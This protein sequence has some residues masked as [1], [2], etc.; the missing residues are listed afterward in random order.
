[1]EKF[2]NKGDFLAKWASG[3]LSDHEKEAFEKIKDYHYY[4]AIL[5]GTDLL[6]TPFYDKEKNYRQVHE[7]ISKRKKVIPLV[8]RWMYFVA[9]ASIV[10][11]VGYYSSFFYQTSHY[12]TE[13]GKQLI[14][15]LPSE[16]EVIL[17]ATSKLHY[18]KGNWKKERTLVLDGQA[19]FKVT[20]GSPFKVKTKNGFIT[21]LGTQF[22]VN[23]HADIF[24]VICFK[25]KVRVERNGLSKVITDGEGIRL[26]NNT[27]FE[28]WSNAINKDAPS[29]IHG[30]SCF[31]NAQLHQVIKAMEN[32]Y[33][34]TFLDDDINLE[35][36]FTGSFTHNNLKKAL[37]TVFEP[38]EIKFT[39]ANE[40]TINLV[41][42]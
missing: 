22:T 8:P 17:N 26:V 42:K 38:L 29:W 31:T 12:H 23:S 28:K 20:K 32:Q 21:V 41:A 5:E 15:K 33:D 10:L 1:M 3:E 36:R 37:R 39:F 13:Y 40:N 11:V 27:S 25:G 4:K 6:K 16:S 35:L 18:K 9:A 14:I 30:E 2:Y 7:K 34:V 24:E 19:Y